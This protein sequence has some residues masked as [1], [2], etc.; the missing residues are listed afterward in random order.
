MPPSSTPRSATRS[1]ILPI[2]KDI[3]FVGGFTHTPNIDA[4]LWFA[5]EIL[6]LI[7]ESNTGIRLILVGSNMPDT[8]TQLASPD[9]SIRG[10]VTDEELDQLYRS[11][12][13]SVIPLRFGAGLK[14]KTVESLSKALPIV[15]TSFGIEGLQDIESFAPAYDTAGAFAEAVITLYNDIPKLEELSAAAAAYSRKHFTKDAAMLFFKDLFH[16]DKKES[17]KN[18][19]MN[20]KQ[21]QRPRRK[22]SEQPGTS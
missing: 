3:L 8:I 17:S 14:G 4:V 11:V 9:I 18:P 6:P 1:G 12:R 21:D 5:S 16:H 19:D 13:F 20:N 15:S 7:R 10:F 22:N 2:T